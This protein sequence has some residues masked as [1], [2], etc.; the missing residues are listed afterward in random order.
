MYLEFPT[1]SVPLD[2]PFYIKHPSIEAQIKQEV[3]KPGALIRI[4]AAQGMG[5][6]SLLLRILEY[7]SHQSYH[8]IFLNLAQIDL[9]ILSDFHRF[10]RW[11]CIN[12]SRQLAMLPKLDNY[13]NQ[14]IGS[15]ISSTLYLEDYLL[16]EI[17]TPILLVLDE[18]DQIFAHPQVAQEFF[19]LLRSWCEEAK[20]LTSWQKLRM[21]VA[22]STEIYVPLQLSHSPFNIGLPIKLPEFS[23][24]QIQQL[25][26]RH[27]L[28]WQTD[29][30]SKELMAMV[31]G[32]PYLVRLA[33]YYLCQKK[34]SLTQLL[35]EAHLNGSIYSDH[36]RTHLANLRQDPQLLEALK[37]IVVAPDSAY[38]DPILSYKLDCLGLVKL[39]GGKWTLSCELYR[40][41]FTEQKLAE[42]DSLKTR[43]LELSEENQKL[44]ELANI[45]EL[46]RIY[47]RRYFN[48]Y[49]AK[50]WQRGARD[51]TPIS[52]LLL[53]ID[54]FKQYNDT[55]GHQQ[56]DFC[57]QKVAQAIRSCLKRPA[58]LAARYGGEEFAVILP[59]TDGAGAVHIATEIRAGI[60][61]LA[62]D[63][64]NSQ[65]GL[66]IVTISI[67]I[68]SI[69]PQNGSEPTTLLSAADIALYES[70][71][72]GRDRITLLNLS[73]NSGA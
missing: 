8:I 17:E 16:P 18:V 30:E 29:R 19:P 44:K 52:L 23:P 7:A 1:G 63:H 33:L 46:T 48:H 27:Q 73:E 35:Q 22:Y 20:R 13:W 43:L 70:K 60:Q 32:H 11:L 49:L 14:D 68:A 42:E 71:E 26:Q 2:S 34:V 12:F 56:G 65:V 10:L 9:R 47:N 6:T 37:Q 41:Y 69:I 38:I 53:D 4:K 62:I 51:L 24:E 5:K 39:E 15:K 31:G 55:Y 64:I 21:V 67:G 54:Y 40:R 72:K 61:A 59:Q 28:N 50:E 36:L 3:S 58:D 45:D 66:G 25:A 57:L